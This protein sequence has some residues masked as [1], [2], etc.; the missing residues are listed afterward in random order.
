MLRAVSL[1]AY[2]PNCLATI[3]V[4]AVIAASSLQFGAFALAKSASND[5]SPASGRTRAEIETFVEEAAKRFAV[6]T[7]WIR[8]I[9]RVES[10]GDVRARSPKGAIGLMQVMPSTYEELR[11]R[12]G[13]GVD[14]FD[15]HDNILAGSAYIR[16][17]ID[18]YGSPGFLAAYNAG[19]ARF[20]R[21]LTAGRALPAETLEYV[22]ALAPMIDHGQLQRRVDGGPTSFTGNDAPLFVLRADGDPSGE[23]SSL[24]MQPNGAST[25]RRIADLSALVPHSN[26][27]FVPIARGS[28][29]Q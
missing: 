8:A 25:A 22:E 10:G 16:E 3:G 4:V 17:L 28:D 23:L 5:P 20:D 27:L 29:L 26:G 13:F 24:D 6:P 12:H 14:P 18:R 15:P 9:M 1:T 21:Y 11:L 19:P 2:V 7:R